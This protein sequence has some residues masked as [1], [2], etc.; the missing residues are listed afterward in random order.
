MSWRPSLPP[1]APAVAHD[2]MALGLRSPDHVLATFVAADQRLAAYLDDVP[3][4]T[5]DRPRIEYYN[6]YPVAP[7]RVEELK[8]LR[9]P[10][11][12]YLTGG[13]PDNARSLDKAR[14]VV[15]A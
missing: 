5:D 9:E 14:D 4:L 8:T 1:I 6:F 2:L 15:E 13:S 12:R 11:E 10:V 3:S 7:I